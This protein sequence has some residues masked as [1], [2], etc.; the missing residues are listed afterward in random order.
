MTRKSILLL[1]LIIVFQLPGC[2]QIEDGSYVEPITTF[3]KINGTWNLTKLTMVD[4]YAK[5]NAFDPV[6]MD[7]TSWFN[8]ETLQIKLNVDENNTPTTY[9]VGGTM[10]EL[11]PKSGYWDLS[12][13]F[14]NTN[15]TAPAINLYGSAAKTDKIGELLL[16]SVPGA[17]SEAEIQLVRYADDVPYVSYVFKLTSA[18]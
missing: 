6:E 13:A 3:E 17:S 12:S 7:L 14:P 8:F 1:W 4:N 16:T 15:L 2:Y 9:E 5:A 10:P 18:N 11:F